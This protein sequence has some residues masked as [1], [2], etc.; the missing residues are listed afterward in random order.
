MESK[1]RY[2]FKFEGTVQGVGFRPFV[3]RIALEHNLGG[4]VYNSSEGVF[5][6]VQGKVSDIE[7]FLKEFD[8]SLPALAKVD[9]ITKEEIEL[10][11]EPGFKII[12]SKSSDNLLANISPDIA[13]CDDCLRELRDKNNRRFNYCL[14]NCTN[15]GPRYTIIEK[16][17]YDRENTSMKKFRM[18]FDCKNEYENPLD[19]RY[20][21]EPISCKVC[22]P[23]TRFY[24]TYNKKLLAKYEDAI[25]LCAKSIKRGGIVAVKGLGGFHIM[26][27]ATSPKSVKVLRDRKRRPTKPL[28]V[29]FK[30]MEDIEKI[31]LLS[32]KERELITSKEKPI[33]IVKKKEPHKYRKRELPITSFVAPMIDRIGVFLPY[34]PLHH[35][36]FDLIECPIVATSANLSEEPIIRTKEEL[37]EKLGFVVDYLLDFDRDIVNACDDSVVQAVGNKRV[38]I[39]LARGYAPKYIKL[40]KKVDKKLLCVGANQKGTITLVQDDM[41]VISP[42]IGDLNSIVSMEYFERTVETFKRF[43]DFEPDIV[44][45]DKHP[46]YETTKWA[47]N[48]VEKNPSIKLE[49]VQHHYAHILACLAEHNIKEKVLGFSWDGTGYGDD[50]SIWGGEVF[51]CDEKEYKRVFHFKPIKLLGGEKAIKE[52][53][54]VGLA[55]LFEKYGLDDIKSLKLPLLKNFSEIELKNYHSL[56]KNGSLKTSSVGRVFDGVASLCDILQVSNYEGESGLI[57]ESF[58]DKNI[59][60]SFDYTIKDDEIDLLSFLD[61]IVEIMGRNININEKKSIVSSMFINTL[62]AVISDIVNRFNLPIV[63]SGGVFQNRTLLEKTVK[64]LQDKRVY[65]QE[66]TPIN[67]GGISLGQAWWGVHHQ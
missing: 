16:V 23:K 43:Y 26:C 48:L 62:E 30:S 28:A 64:N 8:T 51:I 42:Y 37:C 44:I 4:V 20:H 25:K 10:K 15:C 9:K 55:M 1:K 50:G 2:R 18:C 66:E 11:K 57:L 54:R 5:V 32:D 41:M 39:R 14:I 38:T 19:R 12:K 6:E 63:L 52:P 40:P 27:S 7:S 60:D 56:W 45:C 29:M 49:Q 17:P 36:L 13:I 35:M 53:K 67:D 22:G 47:K 46:N 33:V 65:F 21:A 34:T 59:K 58:Y 61:E 31:A 24:K 3:Y